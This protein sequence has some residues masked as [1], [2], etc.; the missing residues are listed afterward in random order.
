MNN[1]PIDALA[2]IILNKIKLFTKA[3]YF[4]IFR[5]ILLKLSKNI[6]AFR[7]KSSLSVS[8]YTKS[9]K[10]KLP[11]F[12]FSIYTLI[13][14]LKNKYNDDD[15]YKNDFEINPLCFR[16]LK[17][18]GYKKMKQITNLCNI[19]N[20]SIERVIPLFL[21]LCEKQIQ[22]NA[23]KN[24]NDVILKAELQLQMNRKASVINS[25]KSS[26]MS[27]KSQ[28]LLPKRLS[29]GKKPFNYT[30]SLTRLFI[31][32]TDEQSIR[33]RYLSNMVVKKHKQLHLLNTY[34]EIS[35]MY[36]KR[37]YKKLFKKDEKGVIDNDMNNIIN[38]FGNDFKKIDNFQRS[39][40]INN[41][42]PHYMYDYNQ[43][44]L[45]LELEKQKQKYNQKFRSQ[46]RKIKYNNSFLSTP[47][48][49]K[50]NKENSLYLIYKS[51]HRENY[52]LINYKKKAYLNSLI[53]KNKNIFLRSRNKTVNTTKFSS[54]RSYNKIKRNVSSF[55]GTNRLRNETTSFLINRKKFSIKNY[56]RKNDFF[57]S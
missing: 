17:N 26:I 30:N 23:Q 37:M 8:L 10:I 42:Q 22:L 28:T 18:L 19:E 20:I 3:K 51:E 35:V 39:S 7:Q 24:K 1:I 43:N 50:N 11:S 36:L 5:S 21:S 29:L 52:N 46:R 27:N 38:K 33:E 13:F 9:K 25:R 47:E 49:S 48:V 14:P 41:D 12:W 15:I 2:D 53:D 4:F 45:A 44:S 6:L 34:G 32:E 31:G 56:L 16:Y 55:M 40:I 54:N 57:Y